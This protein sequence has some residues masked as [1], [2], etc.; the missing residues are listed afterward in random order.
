MK[1]IEDDLGHEI[2]SIESRKECNY[3]QELADR[4]EQAIN[5]AGYIR[6]SDLDYPPIVDEAIKLWWMC[7]Y[8]I[9]AYNLY[10]L[11]YKSGHAYG[12]RL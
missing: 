8:S 5:K 11:D 2:I 3:I 4:L 7:A 1:Y 10:H 6:F 12:E 9:M